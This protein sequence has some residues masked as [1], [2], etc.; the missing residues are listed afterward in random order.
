MLKL[1]SYARF[2]F[3]TDLAP[4]LP[5]CKGL[6]SHLPPNVPIPDEPLLPF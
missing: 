3:P 6:R 4:L 2:Q 1:D 5:G